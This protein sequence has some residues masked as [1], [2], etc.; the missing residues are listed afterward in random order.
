MVAWKRWMSEYIPMYHAV[1]EIMIITSNRVPR[2]AGS[3]N[4]IFLPLFLK[5]CMFP[6]YVVGLFF[7]QCVWSV[8]KM[9]CDCLYETNKHF[10][11]TLNF[12]FFFLHTSFG[13]SVVNRWSSICWLVFKNVKHFETLERICCLKRKRVDESSNTSSSVGLHW[14]GCYLLVRVCPRYCLLFR[15]RSRLT[16]RAEIT[17]RS[18]DQYFVGHI[19]HRQK[20][21][22]GQQQP[23]FYGCEATLF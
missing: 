3:I 13:T 6:S 14:D 20:S 16:L 5:A 17:F 10:F 18:P 8:S 11:K 4:H 12:F 19:C 9:I 1:T 23:S 15:A 7:I 22:T 21:T 2:S